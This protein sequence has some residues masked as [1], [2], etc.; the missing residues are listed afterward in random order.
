M[1]MVE[2]LE[3]LR[4]ICILTRSLNEVESFRRQTIVYDLIGTKD[5]DMIEFQISHLFQ[6][7]MGIYI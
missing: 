4:L 2:L 7:F 5:L 6:W 1:G 3:Q